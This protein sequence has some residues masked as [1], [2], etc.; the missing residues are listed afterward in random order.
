VIALV[1]LLA[2]AGLAAVAF[3]V[4][5]LAVRRCRASLAALG[6]SLAAYAPFAVPFAELRG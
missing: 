4:L 3:S 5:L 1:P 6:V 2:A